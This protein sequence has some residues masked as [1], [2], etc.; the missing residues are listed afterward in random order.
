M[1]K[2]NILLIS[3]IVIILISLITIAGTYAVVINVVSDN[4]VDKIVN[5]IEI[6][7][8]LSNDNGTYNTTYYQVKNELNVTDDE[9]NILINSKELNSK[10]KLVL[11]SIVKYKLRKDTTS[12]YSDDEIYNMIIDSM[13]NSLDINNELKSKV[14]ITSGRYKEDISN[15]LYDIDVSLLEG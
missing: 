15:F 12:R 11:D 13:D 7:D 14:I 4:G 3:V 2:N 6:K 8:L 10:L 9:M 1:K 5:T